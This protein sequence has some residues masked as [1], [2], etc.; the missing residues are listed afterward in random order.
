MHVKMQDD[1]DYPEILQGECRS[2]QLS[3]DAAAQCKATLPFDE[4]I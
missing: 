2:K 4:V 3:V 1:V